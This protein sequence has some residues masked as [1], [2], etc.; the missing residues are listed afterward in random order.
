MAMIRTAFA[1]GLFLLSL[2]WIA[3]HLPGG[4]PGVGG[5]VEMGNLSLRLLEVEISSHYAQREVVIEAT[6][7]GT[8]T[9]EGEYRIYSPLPG[10]V[11]LLL[12][13]E[14]ENIGEERLH[15]WGW[16]AKKVRME[17]G[18][19]YL[20]GL[21]S[22]RPGRSGTPEEVTLYGKKD[23]LSIQ[24]LLPGQKDSGWVLFEVPEGV[25]A[26]EF[27]WYEKPFDDEAAARF[28]LG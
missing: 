4:T 7:F 14:I 17:D 21:P 28:R 6:P 24:T 5:A 25:E 12:H 10:H 18:R 8:V 13:L 27:H 26:A 15:L 2:F 20:P 1:A 9:R 3:A 22:T 11:F 23:F 16:E 19:Y